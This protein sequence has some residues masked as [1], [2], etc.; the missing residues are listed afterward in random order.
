MLKGDVATEACGL[1]WTELLTGAAVAAVV[2]Y[3]ALA[4]L[5]K[6]L[7]GKWFWLFGPY[8]LATGLGVLV[9]AK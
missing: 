7:K 5:V 2:G 9:F 3:A 1:G 4:L 8:C 6:A